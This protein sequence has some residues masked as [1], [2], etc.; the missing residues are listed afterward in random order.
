MATFN[1][2]LGPFSLGIPST[3]KASS[4]LKTLSGHP[5][6]PCLAC[7]FSSM[8]FGFPSGVKLVTIS[9][10]ATAAAVVVVNVVATVPPGKN[11]VELCSSVTRYVEL[12]VFYTECMLTS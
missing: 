4:S 11:Y 7:K 9:D 2:S 1:T 10:A 3:S 12:C 8:I 5:V 6:L